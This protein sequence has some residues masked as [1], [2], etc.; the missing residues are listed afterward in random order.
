[1]FKTTKTVEVKNGDK[2]LGSQEYTKV[3]FEG[4]GLDDK[5]KIITG[6]AET[7]LGD[8]ISFFQGIEGEKGNGV[9]RLLSEATYA[10]DL[11]VRSK[12][13][14]TIVAAMEGPEK[15]I[16]KSIKDFMAARQA[17]GKPISEE[18]ARAKVLA[19]ME[20]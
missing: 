19:M 18:A 6:D 10:Y 2:T 7:L 11:G 16:E 5:K 4:I 9:L 3:V 17:A 1:M 13:R 20:D 15:A 12:I 8:A 14:Q